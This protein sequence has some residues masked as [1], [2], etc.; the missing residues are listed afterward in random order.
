MGLRTVRVPPG[1]ESLFERAE[2]VVSRYFADTRRIPE[3]GAI[4]ICGERYVLVR[5]A[6]L[7]VE[8]FGLVRELLG[9]GREAE[10]DEFSLGILYDLAHAI[11]KAD[12]KSFHEKMGLDDPVARLSAGP[13]HFAYTGWASVDIDGVSNP[14][15]D[16]DYCLVYDHPYSFEA[17]AWREAREEPGFAACIMNAGYSSGWCEE[18]F[19][20]ELASAEVLCRA[21]GDDACRFVMAPPG[22]I[23]ERIREY[24]ASDPELASRAEPP[25]IPDFFARKRLEDELRRSR[26]ELEQR[27]TERTEELIA[28]NI[29]LKQQIAEREHAERQLVQSQKLE[30]LGRLAGGIAHDFNNMLTAI[31]GYAALLRERLERLEGQDDLERFAKQIEGASQRA[32]RLTRQLLVFSRQRMADR[33][34]VEM[35]SLLRKAEDML[36]RLLGEDVRL[37]YD[38]PGEPCCVRAE[39]AQVEQV[40]LNLALNAR[41]AMP[42]GGRLEISLGREQLDAERAGELEMEPGEV[43]LLRVTDEGAGIEPDVIERVFDPFFTTK[44]PGKG[45]G[46]GLA[47]VYGAVRQSGGAID[48]ESEPGK[49]AEF[50]VWL[51]RIEAEPDPEEGAGSAPLPLGEVRTV[52]LV[53]DEDAVRAIARELLDAAGCLILE[54]SSAEDA[55]ERHATELGRVDLLLTDVIMPGMSGAEL[56]ERLQR[57]VPGLR[58]LFMSGY[59]GAA[60]SR[61]GVSEDDAQFLQKP[62]TLASFEAKLRE[63][64]GAPR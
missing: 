42:H 45:T 12:A 29:E 47:S 32:S 19:G 13:V 16:G 8:F 15:P 17:T 37:V 9:T 5:A 1:L 63:L 26:D 7:S 18:S 40:V 3:E 22:R 62:F 58:T 44:G 20:M 21:R 34:V 64:L 27:V 52:L 53:E 38:L 50:S 14:S 36:R 10:A 46:L 35:G 48:V 6:S 11:G 39:P 24:A 33:R 49:G 56:A 43:V 61:H 23:E 55:L 2:E 41:D 31:G 54:A 57:E 4:E 60:L 59:T 51:P 25:A 28:A 30:A